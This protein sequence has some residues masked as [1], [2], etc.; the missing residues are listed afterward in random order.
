MPTPSPEGSEEEQDDDLTPVEDATGGGGDELLPPSDGEGAEERKNSEAKTPSSDVEE[1]GGGG[2]HPPSE[3]GEGGVVK[4]KWQRRDRGSIEALV[5][6]GK[7]LEDVEV[8]QDANNATT[9][10]KGVSFTP[11]A[12]IAGTPVADIKVNDLRLFCTRNG[13][14]GSR[15]VSKADICWALCR[16]KELHAGG[17]RPPY[18]GL[19]PPPN[20]IYVKREQN[21]DFRGGTGGSAGGGGNGGRRY[22]K[23]QVTDGNSDFDGGDSA[24]VPGGEDGDDYDFNRRMSKKR[25]VEDASLLPPALPPAAWGAAPS[26]PYHRSASAVGL[27]RKQQKELVNLQKRLIGSK[28]N[29]N[30]AI[31]M[32]ETIESASA[33]RRELRAEKEHRATLW[34]AF[35]EK[36]GDES[37][38]AAHARTHRTVLAKAAD[39]EGPWG[40]EGAKGSYESLIGD[41]VEQD[42]I[43]SRMAYQYAALADVV[44]QLIADKKNAVSHAVDV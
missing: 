23:G 10:G 25:R 19:M 15:D 11:F 27:N 16:A 14:K 13:I 12:G 17:R 39:G 43:I 1:G 5:I 9:S 6:Y 4:R 36:V 29:T 37:M 42:D 30:R 21:D 28:E 18:K 20:D 24:W 22:K 7:G 41:V 38:A 40:G 26:S 44:D 32:R 34:K 33:L 3:N 35:V 8:T 2:L 31:E